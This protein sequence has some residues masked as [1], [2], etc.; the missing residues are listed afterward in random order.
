MDGPAL[1]VLNCIQFQVSQKNVN[2]FIFSLDREV[3]S[4]LIQITNDTKLGD[5]MNTKRKQT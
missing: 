1:L 4:T 3:H 5:D 2:T